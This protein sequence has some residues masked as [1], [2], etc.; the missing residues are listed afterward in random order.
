E[1]CLGFSSAA[2]WPQPPPS[3]VVRLVERREI[4]VLELERLH[5][6]VQLRQ[7][8]APVL[9]ATVH[10]RGEGSCERVAA[11]Q[12]HASEPRLRFTRP[13]NAT[14]SPG[15]AGWRTW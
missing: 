10:E 2:A 4:G 5:E 11:G 7:V 8:H 13:V 15:L 9:L 12:G 6:L 3:F 1:R 14:V